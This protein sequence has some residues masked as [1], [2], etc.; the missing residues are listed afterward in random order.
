[1]RDEGVPPSPP[2]VA[3]LACVTLALA[4]CVARVDQTSGTGTGGAGGL[5]G[6]AKDVPCDVA[7]LLTSKCISCHGEI[8]VGGA[9]MP[10]LDYADLVAPAKFDPAHTYAEEAVARMMNPTNPM[11]PSALPAATPAEITAL[12]SWIAAGYPMTGCSNASDA[13]NGQPNGPAPG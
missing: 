7:A 12:Q 11:P 9:P 5:A 1:M 13:G 10:L 3:Q 4:G 6:V 2:R 8:L